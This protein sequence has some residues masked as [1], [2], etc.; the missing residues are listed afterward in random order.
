MS[1]DE[2]NTITAQ[3]AEQKQQRIDEITA[4]ITSLQN[5]LAQLNAE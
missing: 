1:Q 2:I 5:Q 3:E 4:Q